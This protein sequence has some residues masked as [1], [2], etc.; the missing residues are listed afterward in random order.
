[1]TDLWLCDPPAH[2]GPTSLAEYDVV[3]RRI[4]QPS[5]VVWPLL[6]EGSAVRPGVEL[7]V[8]GTGLLRLD[9]PFVDD[10]SAATP[11]LR[12]TGRLVPRRAWLVRF[13][14]VR[15]EVARWDDTA[16]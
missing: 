10:P 2:S 5:I 4:N 11:T 6:T 3:A 1:M 16:S 14:R 15:I 12:A 13:A 8:P 9:G 7:A